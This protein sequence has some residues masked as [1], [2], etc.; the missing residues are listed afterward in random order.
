MMIMLLS[1]SLSLFLP[2][3][4]YCSCCFAVS[5]PLFSLLSSLRARCVCVFVFVCVISPVHQRAM[6]DCCC[7]H[8]ASRAR[9]A[10]HARV[11]V[12][13]LMRARLSHSLSPTCAN[14]S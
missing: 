14:E 1:L 10:H 5:S 2:P 11:C 8:I 3:H 7:A 9:A 4:V 13:V 12:Y 6:S